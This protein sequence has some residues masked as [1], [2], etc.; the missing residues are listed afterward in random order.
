[1]STGTMTAPSTQ[2]LIARRWLFAIMGVAG[3]VVAV[4]IYA[5]L[6]TRAEV[7]VI[8]PIFG[9]IRS[10][11]TTTGTVTPANDF[12]AR[13]NFSGLVETIFVHLGEKVRPGQ[14]L[15]RMKDQYAV[16]RVEAA[17]AALDASE[18]NN[19]NVQR[20]GSQEDQIMFATD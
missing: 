3:V 15:V 12:P 14:L 7:R 6:H 5:S 1:M 8:N 13:A 4:W 17:R 9:D 18:M 2:P 11:V 20:N 10:Q 19:E 16:P